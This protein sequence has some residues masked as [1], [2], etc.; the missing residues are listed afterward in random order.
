M[1]KNRESTQ[2]DLKRWSAYAAAGVAAVLSPESAE[3]DITVVE[4]GQE[5]RESSFSATFEQN[6]THYLKF[7]HAYSR[8]GFGVAF[9]AGY[10]YGSPGGVEVFGVVC[11]IQFCFESAL[12][13]KHLVH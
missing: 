6:A 12:W 7:S 5:L 11:S 10:E 3:A 9:V 8:P 13:A 2:I 1:K 4:V